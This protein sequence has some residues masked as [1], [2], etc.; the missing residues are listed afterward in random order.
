MFTPIGFFTP[1]V[2]TFG[3]VGGATFAY[4]AESTT[5]QGVWTDTT[6][7]GNTG[8][9][10]AETNTGITHN[11]DGGG[12][13]WFLDRTNISN[14][15]TN[16]VSTNLQLGAVSSFSFCC[17]QQWGTP[18]FDGAGSNNT[19]N[20]FSVS[21]SNNFY[22]LFYWTNA[23]ATNTNWQPTILI[24]NDYREPSPLN[25]GST[26]RDKWWMISGVWSGTNWKVYLNTVEKYSIAFSKTLNCS[27]EPMYL[28]RFVQG[29]RNR[30]N[31][32]LEMGA[33]VF[34]KNKALTAGEIATNYAYFQTFYTGL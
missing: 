23:T 3:G 2:F 16:Y 7:N 26:M 9:E 17:I 1:S 11:T 8:V 20:L 24:E 22:D 18:P 5:A 27:T 34:Y 14:Y 33:L 32:D 29:D 15:D 25:Q 13:Y 30:S 12:N 10:S 28:H 4:E 6:G 21:T 19:G 31:Q